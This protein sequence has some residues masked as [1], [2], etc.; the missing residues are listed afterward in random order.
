MFPPPPARS[1]YSVL[2][3]VMLWVEGGQ[4]EVRG[5]C[6]GPTL[7]PGDMDPPNCPTL[8][9]PPQPTNPPGL[10]PPPPGAGVA[11]C[12]TRPPAPVSRMTAMTSWWP[13]CAT[14]AGFVLVASVH[15]HPELDYKARRAV[16][17]N[18]KPLAHYLRPRVELVGGDFNM[19]HT[20]SRHPLA[21]ACRNG[22]CMARYR[23][24][25]P[26]DAQ[27]HYTTT[28][29]RH[30]ATSIDHIF[31][32]GARSITSADILPSPTPHRPLVA[33]VE[34]LEALTDVRS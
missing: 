29:H 24:A 28:Q 26:A 9:P 32:R 33:T 15:V 17:I 4:G 11:P 10:P 30:T 22:A 1:Q 27:T 20:N 2:I 3:R 16:L 8:P 12:N 13:S 7:G 19:L 6:D 25:F 31:I 14:T 23:P 34:P 18:L 21:A 5:V